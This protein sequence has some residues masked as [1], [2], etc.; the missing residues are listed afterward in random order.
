MVLLLSVL[1]TEGNLK[2]FEKINMGKYIEA[3]QVNIT[4]EV[5]NPWLFNTDDAREYMVLVK[6]YNPN[7]TTEK[8]T[9]LLICNNNGEI[10][11]DYGKSAELGG[12]INMVYVTNEGGQSSLC[13]VYSDGNAL[14]LNYTPLPLNSL[15][16][17]KGEGTLENP[18]QLSIP[19]DFMKIQEQPSAHYEVVNDVDFLGVP[20]DGVKG[21]FTGTLDGNG[22]AL[23]N[24]LL[25][26]E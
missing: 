24:L 22:Y 3:A 5:L 15:G 1:D 10:L 21:E 18:Y 12:D 19:S 2:R 23:K 13:C 4:A 26:G 20:F 11:L 9:A 17:L 8:E 6:R 25:N 16:N 14:T 7:K